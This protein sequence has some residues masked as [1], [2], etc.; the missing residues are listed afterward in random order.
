MLY[1]DVSEFRM[2]FEVHH[3]Q[4]SRW[5]LFAGM[6][7]L[8]FPHVEHIEETPPDNV[9][10]HNEHNPHYDNNVTTTTTTPAV[11]PCPPPELTDPPMRYG[12]LVAQIGPIL[13]SR[14]AAYIDY[15]QCGA[16]LVDN[17]NKDW[18]GT[19]PDPAYPDTCKTILLCKEVV[20]V[21]FCETGLAELVW[22]QGT[23]RTWSVVANGCRYSFFAQYACQNS[24]AQQTTLGATTPATMPVTAAAPTFGVV[25]Q[26]T[27]VPAPLPA[28]VP[29]P[30]PAPCMPPGYASTDLPADPEQLS[31]FFGPDWR[32][33]VQ[34]GVPPPCPEP[35]AP[36][37]PAPAA[38]CP[39]AVEC[40]PCCMP[41]CPA[42]VLPLDR[43]VALLERAIG[44]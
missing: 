14:L 3:G 38:V 36:E 29:A 42:D 2:T 31:R 7:S 35:P 16:G 28:P 12:S 26:P 41:C 15:Q 33:V 25:S 24:T 40:V 9:D 34:A 20:P 5:F 30:V 17:Q 13:D 19:A 1:N 23:G 21:Q 32:A 44:S 27:P 10:Y 39:P 11:P 4:G 22:K 37:P 6:S 8:A 18:C 43:A